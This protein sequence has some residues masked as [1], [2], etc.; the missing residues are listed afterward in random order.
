[1]TK[2]PSDVLNNRA[3]E[4]AKFAMDEAKLDLNRAKLVTKDNPNLALGVLARAIGYLRRADYLLE[5]IK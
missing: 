5:S 2:M 1:M 4:M 3:I